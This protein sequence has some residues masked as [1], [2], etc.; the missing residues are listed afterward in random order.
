MRK[1]IKVIVLVL[2]FVFQMKTIY[3]QNNKSVTNKKQKVQRIKPLSVKL[4][5]RVAF[6][7]NGKQVSLGEIIKIILEKNL[8]SKITSL[9][10]AMSDSASKKY[11]KKY[12]PYLSAEGGATQS[13]YPDDLAV[14]AGEKNKKWDANVAASKLFLTGTTLSLGAQTE[15]SKTDGLSSLAGDAEYYQPVI[16]ASL[17]QELL[18][19]SFGYTDRKQEKILENSSKIQNELFINQI[20][21]LVV[22]VIVDYWQLALHNTFYENSMLKLKETKLV[23]NIIRKNVRL[24]L[25][26]RF[27]LNY[28]NSLVASSEADTVASLNRVNEI[29]RKVL[30]VMN[31]DSNS[32]LGGITVL[33]GSLVDI[34]EQQVLKKAFAQRVDYK[35]IVLSLENSR[36][37]NDIYS[38]EALPTLTGEAGITY[39]GQRDDLNDAISDTTALKSPSYE[40]R[41]EMSYPLDDAEQKTNERDSRYEIKQNKLR[42]QKITREVKDDIRTRVDNIKTNY[43]LYEKAKEARVQSERYYLRLHSY[44]RRGRFTAA[45]VKNGLDAMVDSRQ[46]ELEALV[47]YN[48]S[49]LELEL[50][51]NELFK[52]YNIDIDK[53]IAT[54]SNKK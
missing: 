20:S 8:D 31:I 38:N 13:E 46:R 17:K 2:C 25:N 45:T 22:G 27:D 26:E 12:S 34:N 11:Q 54:N 16:Y 10:A 41:V 47:A 24:G 40:V 33:R 4:A 32:R 35:N 9:D 29:K 21:G 50:A 5:N 53:Y 19:N 49:L 42:L 7:L 15:Y 30:R 48:I 52:K 37:S 43:K 51:Q 3:S 6:E 36:L 1:Q 23:R 14:T 18:K 44:L 28:W 39:M